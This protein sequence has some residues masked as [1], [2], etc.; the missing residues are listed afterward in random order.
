MRIKVFLIIFTSLSLSSCSSI[1]QHPIINEDLNSKS[2]DASESKP[3]KGQPPK[4]PQ[5]YVRCKIS[6]GA[7]R[8]FHA[9]DAD[10]DLSEAKAR[11]E[12]EIYSRNCI[13]LDCDSTTE[14]D[15]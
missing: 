1:N 5:F 6:N 11:H 4:K 15:D 13:L 3:P 8:V 2:S 12:C 14:E 7:G 10:R 9:T